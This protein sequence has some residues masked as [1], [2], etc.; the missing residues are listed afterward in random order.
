MRHMSRNRRFWQQVCLSIEA[1]CVLAFLLPTQCLHSQSS[2]QLPKTSGRVRSSKTKPG[3]P[4][5][6]TQQAYTQSGPEPGRVDPMGTPAGRSMF[7]PDH[8]ITAFVPR[9]TFTTVTYLTTDQDDK[10]NLSRYEDLQRSPSTPQNSGPPQTFAA[11]GRILQPGRDSLITAQRFGDAG[12]IGDVEITF[13]DEKPAIKPLF[14]GHLLPRVANSSDFLAVTAGDLDNAVNAQGERHDEVVVARVT[15]QST[16]DGQLYYRYCL[17]VLNYGNGNPAAPE[18]S[19]VSF[20]ELAPVFGSDPNQGMLASDNILSVSIGDFQGDGNKEIVLTALGNETVLVYTFRYET[21]NGTHTLSEMKSYY[22]PAVSIPSMSGLDLVGSISSATGDFDGDG[23][24]ELAVA[25]AKRNKNKY[26]MGTLL[27]K[28]NAKFEV[29]LEDSHL[30][31]DP[32]DITGPKDYPSLSRPKVQLASGQFILRPTNDPNTSIPYGRKQLVF[33]WNRA[34]KDIEIQG[35]QYSTPDKKL[36]TS[37]R[38]LDQNEAGSM[39]ALASGHFQG[40]AGE[41]PIASFALSSWSPPSGGG[42]PYTHFKIAAATFDGDQPKWGVLPYR[43]DF[44]V[45]GGYNGMGGGVDPRVHLFLT[46]Y[47][48]PGHSRFLGPPVH[49]RLVNLVKSEYIMPEPPKHAYWDETNHEVVNLTRYDKN[50]VH[51]FNSSGNSVE[52][53]STSTLGRATGGSVS[54]SAGGTVNVGTNVGIL[55]AQ[56]KTSV[57]VSAKASYDYKEQEQKTNG[58]Y[59]SRELASSGQTDRDDFIKGD[60]QIIDIWRYR[61]YGT[62]SENGVNPFY[63]IV[64][65][66][67]YA[68]FASGG[69]NFDWYQPIYE[70]GNILS[71]PSHLGAPGSMIPD[72]LGHFSLDNADVKEPM[73]PARE[74]YFDGTGGSLSL[75]YSTRLSAATT[76]SYSHEIAESGDI[77]VSTKTEVSTPTV[78]GEARFAGSIEAHNNNSWGGTSI[79]NNTA[80]KKTTITLNKTAAQ[81]NKAYPFYTTFYAANDGTLKLAF[82]VPNP[83]DK[84]LNTNGASF[85]ASLYGAKPDPALNL[86]A[87]LIPPQQ[88][89]GQLEIWIPNEHIDR[90]RMRGLFFRSA[91]LDKQDNSYPLLASSPIAGDTIRIEPRVYNFST[92]QYADNTVVEIQV[93]PIDSK[94]NSEICKTKPING[95]TYTNTGLICPRADRTT[96]GK[97]TIAQLKPRQF[98]C[99][100]GFDKPEVTDCAPSAYVNWNTTGFGPQSEEVQ[101]YRVYVVLNPGEAPGT[102]IYGLESDPNFHITHVKNTTPIQITVPGTRLGTGDY[103]TIGGVGGVMAANGAHRITHLSGDEFSLDD[104]KGGSQSYTGGGTLAELDPGQ[105]NEGYGEITIAHA[106]EIRRTANELAPKDYLEHDAL[107][108]ITEDSTPRLA[109]N[110]VQAKLGQPMQLRFTVHSTAAH[111]ESADMLLYDGDPASGAPAIADHAIHPGAHGQKGTSVW[112]KWTPNRLGI[113]RLYAVLSEGTETQQAAGELTVDVTQPSKQ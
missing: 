62:P 74:F 18:V 78:G 43:F 73:V 59:S 95:G 68:P 2:P 17:N 83:A 107:Q 49:L 82:A 53:Q 5:V 26:G 92:G 45:N 94:T 86:P 7:F 56:N 61:V 109:A 39:F 30:A 81:P 66:G 84:D 38:Y 58:N 11:A 110:H 113:H 69:M 34:N 8:G 97:T 6:T 37:F 102:E 106:S 41:A 60:L 64:L 103:V 75:D 29:T 35:A 1:L 71:Y 51:L 112:F 22:L 33:A 27:F 88:G 93:I 99:V 67:P 55:K 36:N 96:V 46:A 44:N 19:E 57:D 98:T 101:D 77:K 15:G 42:D 14:L 72:D 20:A 48:R 108:A 50:N 63:E 91:E 76:F 90:K 85:F 21:V 13:P 70:N 25:Y 54:V 79:E 52:G 3:V 12:Y 40:A 100:D 28:Y 24:D 80:T 105:N 31:S 47:D 16:A 111:Q 9:G 32:N 23:A 10:L 87:R 89:P 104:T 65:P 4:G